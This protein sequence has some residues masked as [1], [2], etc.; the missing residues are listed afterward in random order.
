MTGRPPVM[1]IVI[2][3]SAVAGIWC[4]IVYRNEIRVAVFIVAAVV[5]LLLVRPGTNGMQITNLDVGQGDS[6]L[7]RIYG[8]NILI[9]GG[10]TT[11]KEVG[12]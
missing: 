3:Y 2:Y 7:I 6:T 4:W 8:K 9:D 1:A 10:S 12:R 5:G 11:E